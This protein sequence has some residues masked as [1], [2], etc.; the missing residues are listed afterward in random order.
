MRLTSDSTT[1][2]Y[3]LLQ[4]Y[5]CDWRFHPRRGCSRTANY[6]QE[7]DQAS[8]QTGSKAIYLTGFC[9]IIFCE[10]VAIYGV[11][12]HFLFML[13]PQLTEL[14]HSRS[15]ALCTLQSSLP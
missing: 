4:G 14:W 13:Q 1:L 11:V 6:N 2:A 5:L 10:V 3:P 12:R 8:Q 15:S 9:S 7:L